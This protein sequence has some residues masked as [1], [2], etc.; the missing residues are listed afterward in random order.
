MKTRWIPRR[1]LAPLGF[2]ALFTLA[3]LS[4]FGQPAYA[5]DIRATL[6]EGLSI[7]DQ[8]QSATLRRE[9]LDGFR[10]AERKFAAAIDAGA[11]N[12]AL[13]TNRGNA[14]LQAERL[15][16][17]VLSYRRA[18][19]LAPDDRR[20]RA[21]LIHARS[22][23]PS[24]VPRPREAGLLDTLFFWQGSMSTASQHRATALAF[25]LAA[26]M[27]G[28]ALAF[29]L[30]WLRSLAVL[31]ALIWLGLFAS[32]LAADGA[33]AADAVVTAPEAIARASDSV[34]APSRYGDPLP[35]GTELTL[36]EERGDWVR[37]RLGAEAEAWL[38]RAMV[39]KVSDP[40][41]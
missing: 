24:W 32:S 41:A 14:A 1:P 3:L 29:E 37:V 40:G 19:E 27:L 18:L 33:H 4:A 21:N 38:R 23:L 39:S 26:S 22:L 31:P 15:G 20:A 8:A 10:R 36:V 9:R 13:Y 16:A 34:N 2:C 17:A 12:A 28:L 6:E 25:A 30:S 5:T 11:K 35:A 7:Y